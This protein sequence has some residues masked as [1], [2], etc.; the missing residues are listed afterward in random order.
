M[1]HIGFAKSVPDTF[2]ERYG[3]VNEKIQIMKWFSCE[4][5]MHSRCHL[6]CIVETVWELGYHQ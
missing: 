2:R 4:F 1:T 6:S 5:T 3:A